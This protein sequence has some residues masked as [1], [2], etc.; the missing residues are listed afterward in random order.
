M[1][2]KKI[3][4]GICLL[5]SLCITT[6]ACK[7]PVVPP[8]SDSSSESQQ[9]SFDSS[10]EISSEEDSGS[11]VEESSSLEDSSLESS[12]DSSSVTV[13]ESS[14]S[15]EISSE[16]VSSEEY[17]SADSSEEYSSEDSSEE[18]S[19]EDSSEES[20]SEEESWEEPIVVNE[21]GKI[22]EMSYH[23]PVS[24]A[25]TIGVTLQNYSK[26]FDLGYGVEYGGDWYRVE[27]DYALLEQILIKGEKASDFDGIFMACMDQKDSLFLG[28]DADGG[29]N[30]QAGDSIVFP[31][32]LTYC[33]SNGVAFTTL[34]TF[35]YTWNGSEYDVVAQKDSVTSLPDYVIAEDYKTV[36]KARMFGIAEPFLEKRENSDQFQVVGFDPAITLEYLQALNV[37]SLRL[38]IPSTIFSK[39]MMFGPDEFEVELDA[40]I[41]SYFKGII[42]DLRAHGVTNIILQCPIY[43]KPMGFAGGGQ[44]PTVPSRNDDVYGDWCL[45]ME[46]QWR[47]LAEAFYE[48]NYFEVGNESNQHS[49]LSQPNGAKFTEAEICEINTDWLYYASRGLRKGNAY[50]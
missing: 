47:V 34:F 46:E 49:Y 17:S 45:L 33:N 43:P 27:D 40:N 30:M 23:K 5:L 42:G 26:T 21:N 48:I 19:S 41:V 7:E 2:K 24:N 38:M 39:Y 37:K 14:S 6:T 29:L 20:S 3:C 31:Q 35:T 36:N 1:F 13:E 12:K 22:L 9:S 8:S 50:A 4:A 11:S 32:G 25:G 15:D 16:E 44:S 10:T 28:S 18:Y